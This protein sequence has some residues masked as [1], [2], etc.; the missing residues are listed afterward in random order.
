MTINERLRALAPRRH[1]F[2]LEARQL[3]D[4]A[5][6]TEAAQ[7]ATTDVLHHDS[8]AEAP[9]AI[10][11]APPAPQAASAAPTEVYVVDSHIQNWQSLVS[12]LPQG[13]KVVVLNDQSSGIDQIN[14]ALQ[15]LS[16]IST[17]HILSHGSA[18][19]L[20]L[21][22]DELT[23]ANIDQYGSKLATLGSHL[24][25]SG[26]IL[27][28]GCD[29]SAKDNTL[30]THIATLTQA[31]IAASSDMTGTSRL[32][33]DWQLESHV[34]EIESRSL[35]LDYDSLLDIPE[36]T[37]TS[38]GLTVSE[39][40][41]LRPSAERGQLSG[42]TITSTDL[43]VT[44]SVSIRDIG[45]G[46][47]GNADGDSGN[48]RMEFVGTAADAQVWLN[49]LTFIAADQELGKTAVNTFL[50]INV[51]SVS[52]SSQSELAVTITPSNDPTMVADSA[53]SVRE[54]GSTVI[55]T[56]TLNAQDS[57]VAAG[58]QSWSQ[59]V[60]ELTAMPQFGYMTLNGERLGIGSVF[61]QQD[62]IQGRLQYV[63]TATGA[64][65]NSSDSFSAKVNDGAT[66]IDQSDTVQV[67]L[68]IIPVNQ[69]PTVSGGGVV[70][71]G[72]PD[73]ATDTGNVGQYITADGGGDP[74]DTDLTL[75]ITALPAHGVLYFRGQPV[76]VGQTLSY[77]ERQFLTYANFGEEGVTQDS[78]GVT[79][80]D[81]GGGTG[82]PLSSDGVIR[83]DVRPVN[84]DPELSPDMS[85]HGDV[86]AGNATLVLTPDMLDVTDIDSAPGDIS[87]IVDTAQMTHGYI[88]VNGQRLQ[89]GDSF[90][91]QDVLDGKVI[92]HQYQDA[93]FIGQNDSFDYVVVDHSTNRY[94]DSNGDPHDR[95]GGIWDGNDPS[96]ALTDHRFTIGLIDTNN[97]TN[98]TLQPGP[99][100]YPPVDPQIDIG[101]PGYFGDN[102]NAP[103]STSHGTFNEGGTLVLSGDPDNTTNPGM[104]YQVD[105]I[106]PDQ[107]IYTFLGFNAS[108]LMLQKSDG[109]GNW[110]TLQVY[111]TFSQA[112]LD[113]GLIRLAHDGNETFYAQAR[114]SVSA[115]LMDI[116]ADGNPV[117]LNW[118][119]IIDVYVRPVNDAPVASGSTQAVIREGDTLNITRDLISISDP[120][121]A[122]SG[123]LWETSPD[124]NGNTNYAQNNEASGANALKFVLDSLPPGGQLQYL[125]NGNW[126]TLTAADI[127]TRALDVSL[128]TASA[129]TTGLR[130]VS[131][132][133]ETRSTSFSVHAVDRWGAVSS[134]SATVNII[135]T[136]VNDAPSIAPDPSSPDPVVPG[137]SPNQIGGTPANNPLNVVEGSYGKIGSDL[138]QAYD[139]DST[140]DQVQYT[141]TTVPTQ[142]RLVYTTDNGQTFS[143][144][145]V[146][147]T[148]TQQDIAD[149]HIWYVNNGT[150]GNTTDGFDFTLS[151]GNKEQSNVHFAIN[152]IPAND[153]PVV[154]GPTTIINVGDTAT[155]PIPGFSISD[156]DLSAGAT[157]VDNTMTIVVRL[158]HEDGSVFTLN[159]Y[160]GVTLTIA[161]GS[162]VSGDLS[163]S[164]NYLTF[165]G[166]LAQVNAALGGLSIAFATDRN[167]SYQIQVIADDRL[168]NP[169]GSIQS[170]A[171]GGQVNQPDPIPGNPNPIATTAENWYTDAVPANNGNISASSV[172]IRASS[173]DDPGAFSVP[174]SANVLE[175][176]RTLIPGPFVV[177]DVESNAFN[178]PVTLTLTVPQG[179][180]GIG[181]SGAQT[182]LNGV[183][184]TG[185]NSGTLVLTGVARDIQ[186]LLNDPALGLTYTSALNANHDQNGA[187][188]G[189]VTI[190]LHLDT[191]ASHIGVNGG[192][193]PVDQQ[194]A[195]TIG[196]V[197]DAPTVTAPGGI[198]QLQNGQ[199]NGND[200]FGFQV[201]DIDVT[202]AGGVQAGENDQ[203]QVTIRLTDDNGVPFDL[204]QYRDLQNS[205]VTITSLNAVSSGVIIQSTSVNGNPPYNGE[206][207]PLVIRGS[208]AQ[209]NA[210]LAGLQVTL[211]GIQTDNMNDYIHVEVIVD[212]R[213]RDANGNLIPGA[214]ANG[215]PNSGSG[216]TGTVA[217]PTT[218][219]DP[220][221]A[222]PG[223]LSQNVSTAFVRVFQNSL[224][225][226]ARVTLGD[227]P[228]L[229]V[230]EGSPTVTLPAITVSD[231][232]ALNDVITVDVTLANGFTFVSVGGGASVPGL[233]TGHITLSGTTDQINAQLAGLVVQLPDSP[234][235]AT[236]A[237]WNGAFGVTVVVNDQGNSG[238]R[239]P[240]ISN[241]PTD[242]N[243]DP[244]A[245]SYQD[246]TSSAL[247]TTR[248]FTFTVN[249]VNDAPVVVGTPTQT[250]PA[251]SEDTPASS[252]TA[253]SVSSLFFGFYDDSKDLIN[254]SGNGASGGTGSDG[255]FGVAINQLTLN[256]AQGVW[257]YSIN[258]G[259]SWSDVGA[260]SDGNALV[261]SG[262]ALLRFVPAANFFGTPASLGVRL[263]EGNSNKDKTSTPVSPDNNQTVDIRNAHG[264][265]SLYSE[266]VITLTT[267]VAGVNDHPTLNGTNTT[268]NEDAPQQNQTLGQLLQGTWSDKTDDQSAISGGGKAD[269]TIQLIAI[270]GNTVD[271]TKGHWEYS[272]N[273]STWLTLPPGLSDSR[274]LILSSSTLVRF[275]PL[276]DYNG[277]V[278]GSLTV[279]ASDSNDPA[280][281]GVNLPG[282]I[283]VL[284]NLDTATSHWS[285]AN[286]ISLSIQPVQDAV[287]DVYSLHANTTLVKTTTDLLANDSFENA[288]RQITSVTQPQHG[289]LT[290][291]NG[292]L[293]YIPA[294]GYVGNDSYTYTVT[295]GGV[296]ETATVTLHVTNTI[297]N[298]SPDLLVTSE[299]TPVTGNVLTN[300]SDP[301]GDPISVQSF[302]I[303]G[304]S[305]TAGTVITLANNRGTLQVNAD[306]TV[307]YTSVGDWNG[308]IAFQYVV[309]DGNNG[310]LR[311]MLAG[312][313]VDP[314]A[315]I[316]A[317]V[318]STHAGVPITTDVLAND[319]F[320][321]PD[322]TV[323]A[324]SQGTHGTVTI[325]ANNQI[326]YTP[327]PGFVG[328]DSYTYTV[329]S[330]G[331]TERGTVFINV[332]NTEPTTDN[333]FATTPEDTPVSGNLLARIQ[334]PD[335]D[336]IHVVNFTVGGQ[337]YAAGQTV[338]LAGYGALT[339]QSDGRWQFI[340][341]ADWNG[342]LPGPAAGQPA[343]SFTISDGNAGGTNVGSLDITVT[344]V[345]DIVADTATVHAG[346][347]LTLN[348][349]AND[350]FEN[351]N[352]AV[353]GVT[354]PQ[355]GT[356]T[357]TGNQLIYTPTAG[358]VGTDSF[359]YTVTSGGVTETATITITVYNQ[360]PVVPAQ[361][362]ET[363]EDVTL[364]GTVLTGTSDPEND[365]LRVT[366]FS[367]NGST[368]TQ[369]PG[370]A[371][372]IAGQGVFT[373]NADGTYTFV[374]VSDWHG[375][376]TPITFTLSDGSSNGSVS[377]TLTITV[378]PVQDAFNDTA[379]VHAGDP[380]DIT[381]LGN[382]TFANGDK[383]VSLP[384]FTTALGGTITV[385][386]NGVVTYTPPAG[387]ATGMDQFTYTVTSG[388]ITETA[389]VV[390]YITNTDPGVINGS[391]AGPED[392]TITGTLRAFD[393]DNDVVRFTGFSIDGVHYD[394]PGSA[395]DLSGS[396]TVD[397]PNIGR[398]TLTATH[399]LT[400]VPIADW[401]GQ[402]PLVTVFA[403]DD[404]GGPEVT[405]TGTV[406]IIVT[407][408]VDI[409]A[410]TITTHSGQAITS[411]LLLNDNFESANKQI[412]GVTQPAHGT[413][414]IVNN[415]VVYT[416]TVGYVGNDSYTYTV[417]T[418]PGV[419]ETA[420]V[421]VIVTNT[422][423]VVQPDTLSGNE[424][425][426]LS[427]NV[428]ANDNDPDGDR[429]RVV[430]FQFTGETATHAA[431]SSFTLAGKGTF[432]LNSDGSY[433][434]A[435]VADWN[436]SIPTVTYTVSDGNSN[437][438]LTSTLTL[439]VVPVADIA[440]D[441]INTHSGV[442]I[443]FD[444]LRNDTFENPDRTITATSNGL[445]GTVV[446]EN[447]QL[448]YTPAAGYVGTD[449]FTYTVT[450][451]GINETTTVTVNITN[452][453]PVPLPD[454]SQ[455]SEDRI[456]AGN[457]LSNDRDLDN[458]NL[459]VVSY[460]VAGSA[461]VH[462]AG[463]AV[464]LPG[465][466]SLAML[467][468]GVWLFNPVNDWN[469]TLPVITYTMS[470]G[471]SNG[472]RTSTLTI[473]VQPVQDAFNDSA[474]TH[475][476]NPVDTN[477]LANDTFSNPNAQ[478]VSTTNGAHGTVTVTPEGLVRYTPNPGYVGSDS[479]TYTVRSGGILETATVV[480]NITDTVP[481][482]VDDLNLA[483][484]DNLL[485]GNVL[486]NDS[487]P[488]N[489]PLTVVSFEVNGQTH[490]A[491][492][493]V[494]L[495]G[496]G[497][498]TLRADGSYSFSPVADWNG[499]VPRI[500]YTISDG[501]QRGTASAALLLGILPIQDAFDDNATTH[502]N[503]AVRVDVLANDTFSNSDKAL[504]DF[505]QGSHGSVIRVG[506]QLIYQPA[507]G[508]VGQDTFTYTV[509]SGGISETAT[510]TIVV[511]NTAPNPEAKGAI[512]GQGVA[513]GGNLLD[514]GSDPDGDPLFVDQF[515]IN[516]QTFTS[517]QTVTLAGQGQLTINR[518]GSWR[519][520]PNADYSGVVPL[521]TWRASDGNDGGTTNSLLRIA[522][523]PVVNLTIRESTLTDIDPDTRQIVTSVQLVSLTP[524]TELSFN[525]N[526]LTL[527]QLRQLSE[528]PLEFTSRQGLVQ[529]FNYVGQ[530]D[531]G[532]LSYRFILQNA[533]N[534]P[535]VSETSETITWHINGR[536][537]QIGG[538]LNITVIDDVPEANNNQAEIV[539]DRSQQST[540]GNL[541]SDDRIGADNA[542]AN[543][544][545][546]AVVSDNTGRAG[547]VGGVTSGQ[548]GTLRLDSQGNW[549]YQLDLSNAQ[550]AALDA[551]GTLTEVFTYTITDSDGDSATATLTVTIYGTTPPQNPS[552]DTRFDSPWL[553]YSA[554]P[555]TTSAI[556]ATYQPGLFILPMI[557][558]LEDTHTGVNWQPAHAGYGLTPASAPVMQNAV[559][560]ERMLADQD[561]ARRDTPPTLGG[562]G[563][564]TT[565]L[566]DAFSPFAANRSS[567]PATPNQPAPVQEPREPQPGAP[568][569]SAQLRNAGRG[570][571]VP[572]LIVIAPHR[573]VRH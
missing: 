430:S 214:N 161:S 353:T 333:I 21:G 193:V 91:M 366:S 438:T 468:N 440:P 502:A 122:N 452:T 32:G 515:T 450:S 198:I 51:R 142:G 443:L 176:Q 498:L 227:N 54:N 491:G 180:L 173:T 194:I 290:F 260:R 475:A 405:V 179:T 311:S 111:G 479:Y 56:T 103:G 146:G 301:D 264:G 273:G 461:T 40:T 2:A 472:T 375:A 362:A 526:I 395:T 349:L 424:D 486:I 316:E 519:F 376:V 325:G 148:F 225:D 465:Q 73:N 343:I 14:Q 476:G 339:V 221:A 164:G 182:T 371:V 82:S 254:N 42:W 24:S 304:Q 106:S 477:V 474:T 434:F 340:P 200:V 298:A 454:V 358:Y 95:T 505:T 372:T 463:T 223:G 233:G 428:L 342:S 419:T 305:Y 259:A 551:N 466:G 442:S 297:P 114:F 116:G 6:A 107:V 16:N 169:D 445:W 129:G 566:W 344:P 43:I 35:A 528:T 500:T 318:G 1:R 423:P 3:F 315:D 334:D 236:A 469:G 196:I 508:F 483:Q 560:F 243:A 52:G 33:G 25:E 436:G 558:Q 78:F 294:Q 10:T 261:L 527:A 120:D 458:D 394:I 115:G 411:D 144:L 234:G 302:T 109:N 399:Q 13:S 323:T 327:D 226:P 188:A 359:T 267:S 331:V 555:F 320:V 84:D 286:T 493:T 455:G 480:V 380:L 319:S 553:R 514:N 11:V 104:R 571:P 160:A 478:I 503:N 97:Q 137:D 131:D 140:A 420:T 79:V 426:V 92:Y 317:D 151:D 105:D 409:A 537:D 222:L 147:S 432:T 540:Q 393:V 269:G 102:V 77:S 521:V 155:T 492:E 98:G 441:T 462:A 446:I 397:I 165:S 31:D 18:D 253:S 378:N 85:G 396:R 170:A 181:G 220:L 356:V 467:A 61:T 506:D 72:Q 295:S 241:Q 101:D 224:N 370:N 564:G 444:P 352:A 520:V 108:G 525:G 26:D 125:S 568:S 510:V 368:V 99:D 203:I 63:H 464:N 415:K 248:Q 289:T 215:G 406:T 535:G 282:D 403:T 138:L 429:L 270:T 50:D 531:T 291:V 513:V 96:A 86:N 517:G 263:V 207:S 354:Q 313:R 191:Q 310:G 470:D 530:G 23:T 90:T 285:N 545:V 218:E 153:P 242:P 201:G 121:D 288:D 284:Q 326:I 561:R 277:P 562:H 569:L 563:L 110:T 157:N 183:T 49:S 232:D 37:T 321:N 100:T 139:P 543:G 197:N 127:G 192:P 381:V 287:G 417:T 275:V 453:P 314:V 29:I 195:V 58:G 163:V 390:V 274:A 554:A 204:I 48:S 337:T 22:S 230:D 481:V 250:L 271:A 534:Q 5:A 329:T 143:T 512:T 9:K 65:Q 348:P 38:T 518:D 154:T 377:N 189:D 141:L 112:D 80:T 299:D 413:V 81:P 268:I 257:Q 70:Y 4:G 135:I 44:V 548:Y 484:E 529:L 364:N 567:E 307:H 34:G 36:A 407:P 68:N 382:D 69:P 350:N 306:G 421:T 439:T 239:L 175:D 538:V 437:G 386:S 187:T 392:T 303:D 216:N 414:T 308:V 47:L 507:Q 184:I 55:D 522:V 488:D 542:A 402:V 244:G 19:N 550:V 367:V 145:G 565:L 300:D 524:I 431:G 133:G 482:A 495:N 136:S 87:I 309:S 499:A 322:R 174:G 15:G 213:S 388:G 229:S 199:P 410:D 231:I 59:V 190:N 167:M 283:Y 251:V 369:L 341:V 355:H 166:T 457:V 374:P 245:V 490:L 262:S 533:L 168:R 89:T 489:D 435:P 62:V 433:S 228:A 365:V 202:D 237:D 363:N 330:G 422:P 536:N 39:P 412:T 338:N 266:T 357:R 278:T 504:T 546:T 509:V 93:A 240:D 76:T 57:D 255:I 541:F 383:T 497:L 559:L 53:L 532:I 539:Q 324:V 281:T 130:F 178:L 335:G 336:P 473:T 494:T 460:T 276:A 126:I 391:L 556:R 523:T 113:S 459:K 118:A 156:A 71:E 252:I 516:G 177:S 549:Q 501:N 123:T 404:K 212:D 209:I 74:Q 150:E 451:G 449:V 312:I 293:T 416:P 210:F 557:Y 256:P 88:T 27:L 408:V 211:T 496:V 328:S 83:L 401:N 94:W 41:S 128:L 30:I 447:G 385:N 418:S 427:G 471:N 544:P 172:V 217:P 67:T 45:S 511:T 20:G 572:E 186:A 296:T 152:Q 249:A 389:T 238:G 400:F 60:Y 347:S 425:T 8:I 573:S 158:L 379:T 570:A 280:E 246:G 117:N 346:Q 247:I 66:P 487:D 17:L 219:F 272:L 7:H 361:S 448:R 332:T 206:R 547:T 171:N 12:Q 159:D 485:S 456:Q 387:V 132:G 258:N 345:Q 185:D 279:R 384:Q 360:A 208:V 75:T 162:G 552:E 119:P 64:T 351:S 46:T 149:G 28:Y 235:N 124:L 205:A 134:G 398:L 292:I 265:T 373:L